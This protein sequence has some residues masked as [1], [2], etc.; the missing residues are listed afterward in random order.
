MIQVFIYLL[1][2]YSITVLCFINFNYLAHKNN[3]IAV[4]ILKSKMALRETLVFF[5]QMP[6]QLGV[7]VKRAQEESSGQD[8]DLSGGKRLKIDEDADLGMKQEME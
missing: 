2:I 5:S 6:H 4:F 3:F 8:L 7:Q 1:K